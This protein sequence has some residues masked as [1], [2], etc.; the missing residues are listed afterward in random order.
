MTDLVHS[1]LDARHRALGARMVPFGGWEMPIQYSS[2][3]D[4]HRACREHAVVFDVSHLGSVRVWGSGALD[5]LQWAFTN[6][7]RRIAP[8]HAQ[9]THL[10]DPA[11]A[12]VVDEAPADGPPLQL[13]VPRRSRAGTA[14][15]AAESA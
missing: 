1:P 5:A 11:D 13:D 6:D 12:H 10:L 7:L 8:G 15:A 3:L 2:V 4:E 9:Y 14:G